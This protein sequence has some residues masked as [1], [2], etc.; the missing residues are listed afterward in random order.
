M[1]RIPGIDPRMHELLVAFYADWRTFDEQLDLAE[2][3]LPLVYDA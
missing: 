1:S 2:R 3:M